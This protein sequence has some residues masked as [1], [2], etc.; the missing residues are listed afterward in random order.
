MR[1]A[2]PCSHQV[3]ATDQTT[4]LSPGLRAAFGASL[5]PAVAAAQRSPYSLMLCPCHPPA[6]HDSHHCPSSP[7]GGVLGHSPGCQSPSSTLQDMGATI[8]AE[9]SPS[10]GQ[11][12]VHA[13]AFTGDWINGRHLG[14]H[15]LEKFSS[16]LQ[17]NAPR[18]QIISMGIDPR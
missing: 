11:P 5:G 12:L 6:G 13:A 7:P 15:L 3:S 9:T 4:G 10:T 17:R 16:H 18:V 14:M 1:T 8:R 2:S